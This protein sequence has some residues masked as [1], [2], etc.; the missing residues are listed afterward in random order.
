MEQEFERELSV[1]EMREEFEERLARA[2]EEAAARW[3]TETARRVE[4][5]LARWQRQST[6]TEEEKLDE[7]EKEIARR[8]EELVHRELRAAAAAELARRGLPADIA[9]ALVFESSEACMRAIDSLEKAFRNAV[10]VEVE[11]RLSGA[12]PRMSADVGDPMELTDEQY[13]SLMERRTV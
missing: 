6:L 9:D 13:Y 11:R 1:D 10:G 5:S 4:E 12:D 8:E 3:E 7:R 2:M